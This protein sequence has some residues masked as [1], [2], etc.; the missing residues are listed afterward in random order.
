MATMQADVTVTG[1]KRFKGEI[2][3]KA[4]DSFKA[5]IQEKLDDS[6]G[7]A[8]GFGTVEYSLGTSD[9]FDMW[10][11]LDFPVKAQATYDIVAHGGSA[12]IVIT[13]LVPTKKA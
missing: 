3:G 10:K 9:Q 2:E 11:H 12:K 7:N 5:F 6:K 8:K 1:I 13:N 4:F